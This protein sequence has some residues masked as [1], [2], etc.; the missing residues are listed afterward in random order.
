MESELEDARR[1]LETFQTATTGLDADYLRAG[2]DER[3]GVVKVAEVALEQA[4]ARSSVPAEIDEDWRTLPLEEKREILKGV[5]DA[6]F[7]RRGNG[8]SDG[9]QVPVSNRTAIFP[10]GSFNDELPRKGKAWTAT[11]FEWSST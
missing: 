2:L 10:V 6:V 1:E 9:G 5:L 4:L 7:V 3:I 8:A 11:P